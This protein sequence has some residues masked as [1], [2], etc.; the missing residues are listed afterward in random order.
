MVTHLQSTHSE[1]TSICLT[2]K[3]TKIMKKI[4]SIMVVLAAVAFVGCCGKTNKKAACEGGDCAKVECVE[5]ACT[6]C[7]KACAEKKEC[8]KK[9]CDKQAC[10]EKKE[11]CKAECDKQA[12]ADKKECCKKA[13]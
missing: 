8:C 13:Q 7:E 12:C 4:I 6:D 5:K 2:K 1:K 9:E 10:A 3:P 11:C